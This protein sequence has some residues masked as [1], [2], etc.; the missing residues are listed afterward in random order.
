M[1]ELRVKRL[2]VVDAERRVLG[3]VSRGDLLRVFLRPDDE[4]RARIEESLRVFLPQLEPGILI[5]VD[6]GI[7]TVE[8][9]TPR[10]ST[11]AAIVHAVQ[12]V[13]GVV[14]IDQRLAF[15]VDDLEPADLTAPWSFF[16]NDVN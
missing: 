1:H 4:I 7:V 8:G 15:E 11:I 3:I 6:E 2:P 10:R 14:G 13:P 9:E 12:M 16:A 5:R